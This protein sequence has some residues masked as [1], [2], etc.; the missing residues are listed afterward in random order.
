MALFSN[1]LL[2]FLFWISFGYF[3]TSSFNFPDT[4]VDLIN[5]EDQTA[6]ILGISAV[7]VNDLKQRRQRDYDFDWDRIL[8]VN[9]DTGIKLQYTHCRLTSL[10]EKQGSPIV[11]IPDSKILSYSSFDLVKSETDAQTLVQELENFEA[12]IDDTVATLE[13]CVLVKYLF[14]LCNATSKALK[15]INVRNETNV[16]LKNEKLILFRKSKLVLSQGMQ[17]L[18]LKPL[19]RM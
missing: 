12:V 6:D 3:L 14:G 9:G 2:Y 15:R 18:G 17:I 13:A 8:Q 7:I 11:S 10:L 16:E 1:Y 19:D 4:K 5:V